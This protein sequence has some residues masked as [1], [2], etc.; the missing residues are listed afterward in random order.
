MTDQ[1]SDEQTRA[2]AEVKRAPETRALT[3]LIVGAGP[4]G[5][6]LACELA[7]SGVSFRLI[8]AAPGPQPG[9]R[10]KGIQPRTLE[11]FDDLG[12]AP[13]VIAN[14]QLAMPIRST[15]HDGQVTLSG[16]ETPG[17]RPDIPYSA[18]LITPEWRIEE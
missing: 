14:G 4:T 9:S 18:S 15:A 3:V 13:R 1:R 8:E 5:L 10:G 6:T 16:S 12:I 7:R 2:R 17:N 11:V